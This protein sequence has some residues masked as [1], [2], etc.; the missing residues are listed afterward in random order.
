MKA[1]EVLHA[2]MGLA[3][4]MEG[5]ETKNSL[6]SFSQVQDTCTT[7]RRYIKLALKVRGSIWA[8][9]KR[10]KNLHKG[11][12]NIQMIYKAVEVDR[13]IWTK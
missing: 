9:H 2:E 12:I 3:E 1:P 4:G 11:D 10:D 7:S 6:L 8:R 13:I 5:W